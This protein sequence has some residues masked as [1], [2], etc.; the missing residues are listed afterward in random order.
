MRDFSAAVVKALARREPKRFTANLSLASRKGKIFI[1]YL[2]NGRGATAV[3]AYSLRA[4]AGLPVAT[5]VDWQELDGL[6]DPAALNFRTVPERLAGLRAD[7]WAG[8][9]EAAKSADASKLRKLETICPP[10]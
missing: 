9:N 7:P 10:P 5:P 1:D 6:D 3:A 4:R 2:R 8:M